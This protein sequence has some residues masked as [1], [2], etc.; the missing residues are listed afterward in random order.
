MLFATSYFGNRMLE[1]FRDRDLPEIEAAGCTF[2]LHT[3]S[4]HDLAFYR[5]TVRRLTRRPASRRRR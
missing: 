3:F 2:V 4:E 1:H 5:D